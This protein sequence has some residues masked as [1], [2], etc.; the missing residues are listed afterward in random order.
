[1]TQVLNVWND[2]RAILHSTKN[3][4]VELGNVFS[5]NGY[6]VCELF[7]L[8]P[9]NGE[10]E[11]DLYLCR[12]YFKEDDTDKKD[13]QGDISKIKGYKPL[14]PEILDFGTSLEDEKT[15]PTLHQDEFDNIL[16]FLKEHPWEE[17]WEKEELTG[18]DANE[19]IYY[20]VI[21]I[22]SPTLSIL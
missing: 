5:T 22:Y 19:E 2:T 21:P 9:T 8:T 6:R 10:V 14:H 3:I 16:K 17:K 18:K 13:I 15:F 4:D 7:A 11:C 12:S 1:M 20:T